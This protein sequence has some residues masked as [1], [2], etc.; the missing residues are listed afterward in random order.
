MC[1][2]CVRSWGW[3]KS[4]CCH[5]AQKGQVGMWAC[6]NDWQKLGERRVLPRTSVSQLPP[7]F[8]ECLDE[9][10][11]SFLTHHRQIP[12][13]CWKCSCWTLSFISFLISVVLLYPQLWNM[14]SLISIFS[15]VLLFCCLCPGICTAVSRLW[16]VFPSV[17]LPYQ[18]MESQLLPPLQTCLL[19]RNCFDTANA[20]LVNKEHW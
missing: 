15:S 3:R 19:F 4:Q 5:T 13:G 18:Q 11:R 2:S 16:P 8:A 14:L 12:S 7:G 17:P 10:S 1:Q 6:S 20:E 9:F